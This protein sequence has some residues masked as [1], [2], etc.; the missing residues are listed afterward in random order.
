MQ[1]LG[2]TTQDAATGAVPANLGID[3]PPAWRV[4][5]AALSGLMVGPSVLLIACFGVFVGPLSL[6]FGWSRGQIGAGIGALALAIMIAAPIHGVL[7]DRYG[8][9]RLVLTCVPVFAL[10]LFGLALLPARLEF[11]YA[12]WFLLPFV[13]I[14]LWPVTYLKTVSGW[15][16]ARLGL[17][18]GVANTGVGLGT[19]VLPP[20]LTAIIAQFGVRGGYV[21][22]GVLALL[23]LPLAIPLLREHVGPRLA[24]EPATWSYNAMLRDPRYRR[25]AI[26]FLLIG[27][28]GTP[29][30][31]SLVPIM[32]AKGLTT[33][34][35]LAGMAAYGVTVLVGRLCTGMLLDRFHAVAVLYLLG[36][37]AVAGLVVCAVPTTVFA[38][39]GAAVLLGL[40]SGGEF[41]VLAYVLR[42]FYGLA[43]FGKMYGGAFAMFQLGGAFGAGILAASIVWTGS[44]GSGLLVLAAAIGASMV[45]FATIGPYSARS[46]QTVET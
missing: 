33:G 45:T 26:A 31:A 14:G 13:S 15:F 10:G 25:I 27:T 34:Q 28:T 40:L 11:F 19:I 2:G 16:D 30:L 41:D 24:A 29:L 5:G 44:Y 37:T 20:L 6:A 12:A 18:I 3:G 1:K 8:A 39:L 42:R 4:V 46:S 36:S 32:T 38:T 35:A 21:G 9:R 7:L 17:G 43:S 23:A 22:A